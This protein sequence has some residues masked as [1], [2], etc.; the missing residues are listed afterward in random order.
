MSPMLDLRCRFSGASLGQ[1]GSCDCTKKVR[2]CRNTLARTLWLKQLWLSGRFVAQTRRSASPSANSAI[3]RHILYLT[4]HKLSSIILCCRRGQPQTAPAPVTGGASWRP[5][6]LPLPRR[7]TISLEAHPCL[8]PL[9]LP[10]IHSGRVADSKG[11]VP[12]S[13]GTVRDGVGTFLGR[14]WDGVF[15]LEKSTTTAPSTTYA[16]PNILFFRSLATDN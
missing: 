8:P 12:D 1:V 15:H 10:V 14:D 16:P 3:Y 4:K 2:D 11:T 13:F 9:P 7:P 5:P 6:R